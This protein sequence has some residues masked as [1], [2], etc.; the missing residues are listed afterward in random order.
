MRTLIVVPTYNEAA[1]LPELVERSR[2]AQPDTD[3]LVVDDASPDGT[4]ALAESLAAVHGR[5]HVLR[6][7]GKAGLGSAYRE[8]FAW[9]LARDYETF[10]EMDADLS[11]DPADLPRLLHALAGADLVIGSRYVLG[12]GVV[13]WRARREALSR[14]GNRYVR[15]ATGLPVADATSGYRAFRRDTLAHLDVPRLTSEGYCFQ[16]ETALRAWQAGLRVVEV[17]ITFTERQRGASKIGRQVVAEAVVRTAVWGLAGPRRPAPPPPESVVGP[18]RDGT[19][20][21]PDATSGIPSE[22][23]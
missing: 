21:P 6:R 10:V 8:G 20:R 5:L 19:P 11:H 14:L 23:A 22:G 17:P 9:G 18:G 15:F 12:G 1:N 7:P 3:L 2:A 16:V 13:D 4:G